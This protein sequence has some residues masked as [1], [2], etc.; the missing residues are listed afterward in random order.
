M[1]KFVQQRT[2]CVAVAIRPF[3]DS[4]NLNKSHQHLW[5][6]DCGLVPSV[7]EAFP[8]LSNI[9]NSKVYDVCA[10]TPLQFA[11]KLSAKVNGKVLIKRED[12]QPVFSF[13]LR[14]A[15]N[16]MAS[17]S[18][19]QLANGVAACSAGN[20]AQG[21]GLAAEKLGVHAKIFMP[22]ATPAI[23]HEAVGRFK[24]TE[25]LLIGQTYDEAQAACLKCVEEEGRTLIH[26]FDDPLVIAGQGTIGM[27][28]MKQT[29]AEKVDAIFVCVG[30]GGLLSG[31][32]LY[33][34]SLNPSIRIIGVEAEDAAG[35]TASLRAGKVTPL[36][37]VG[38]FADGAAVK[39]VGANTFRISQLVCDEMITVTT[40][41]I[42]A[43]I[44]DGFSDTRTVF[45]PAGAL[46]IAG[47]T[48]YCR[49]A[50]R[51]G[52]TLVAISSGANMDFDRLRF[53][54]ERADSSETI[55]AV[56][57]PE[58][59]GSFKE[60]YKCIAP[61]NVTE[62]SYRI[63]SGN[64]DEP[65]EA[66][67][68]CSF[69][70][71]ACDPADVAN[72]ITAIKSMGCEIDDLRDNEMAKVHGRHLVGGRVPGGVPDEVLVRFEFPEKP[73]ALAAFLDQMPSE[74]NVSLFHYRNHGSD[75]GRVLAGIVVPEHK[76]SEFES[77]LNNL[78]YLWTNESENSFHKQFLL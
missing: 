19:Q 70:A 67:I 9:L 52:Q 34:K 69:Q 66:N 29:T 16:K 10:E 13:K 25:V 31:V 50:E 51:P 48:K 74:L 3:C 75:I 41:E 36:E 46:S 18:K 15:Y 1:R 65:V 76:R 35:M 43:A 78:G 12:L 7:P 30:G 24:N 44:K 5:V 11:P 54:S 47:L 2:A 28:I 57:I 27:E 68:L 60:F 8:L 21:V 63:A 73:G 72:V 62:F 64:Q 22:L 40:D 58:R 77:Y 59:P 45:E 4:R 14:G 20:H 49:L 26:P 33:I 37:T 42:C 38:L 23:K 32:G 17:L 53:V 6:Q 61:R 56:R 55:V 71:R 39:I